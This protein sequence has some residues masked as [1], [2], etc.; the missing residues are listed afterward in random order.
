ME[1]KTG[2]LRADLFLGRMNDRI[3]VMLRSLHARCT[4][5]DFILRQ[6][7]KEGLD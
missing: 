5:R 2:L 3:S 1:S 4:L 6:P 7:Q